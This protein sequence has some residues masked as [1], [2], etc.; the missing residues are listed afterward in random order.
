MRTT[1]VALSVGAAM[2]GGAGIAQAADVTSADAQSKAAPPAMELTDTQMQTLTAGHYTGRWHWGGYWNQYH[3]R[4]DNGYHK[5]DY[6]P[7]GDSRHGPNGR[8]EGKH[9]RS[10]R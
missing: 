3:R 7:R 5:W 6:G 2:L 9:N 4:E 8:D 1:L 10:H